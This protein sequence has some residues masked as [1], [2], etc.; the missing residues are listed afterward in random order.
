MFSIYTKT[1]HG[2]CDPIL[3]CIEPRGK[4]GLCIKAANSLYLK[5]IQKT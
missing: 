4:I 5:N 2:K 3:S 1:I